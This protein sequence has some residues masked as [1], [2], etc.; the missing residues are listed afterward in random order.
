ME[1]DEQLLMI[2]ALMDARGWNK[3]SV[4]ETVLDVLDEE[5]RH[6]NEVGDRYD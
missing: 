1:L 6:Q 5:S 4:L 3:W 2:L